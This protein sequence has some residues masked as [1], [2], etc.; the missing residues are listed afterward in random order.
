MHK[1]IATALV[2]TAAFCGESWAGVTTYT[3]EADWA[4][5][6]ANNYVTEPFNAG[7]L[8]SFTGVT[9]DAGSIGSASGLLTGSV[10]SDR[11]VTGGASTTFSYIPGA[12][13][14]AGATWD[15]SPGGEGQGLQLTLNLV[16]GGTESVA[17]IG[18][19][20]N[21]FFGFVS[22]DLFTSFTISG[23]TNTGA[24]E[25]YDMTNLDFAPVPEPASIAVLGAAL[26]G[27]GA[28]R[29]RKTA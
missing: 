8:Q 16:G 11:V 26:F 3:T 1:L 28:A 15:T 6:V 19:I 5:A 29:R 9:T 24:A 12:L 7:G 23:G 10:W 25:T 2:M 27:V 18:P 4:T 21:S 17:Q 22:T 14:G 13:L 20:D